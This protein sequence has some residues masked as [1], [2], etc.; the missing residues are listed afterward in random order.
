MEYSRSDLIIPIYIDTNTLL[1]LLASIEGGFSFVEK[2]TSR[3]MENTVSD[4]SAKVEVGTEFGIPNVL[5]LLK[6][7]IDGSAGRKK[8]EESSN[9]R[10]VER[11]HTYGS[12]LYR[13]RGGLHDDQMIKRFDGTDES[14]DTIETSDFVELRG[15]FRPNPF[16]DSLRSIERMVRLSQLFS[17]LGK[18]SSGG[19]KIGGNQ[20]V[21]VPASTATDQMKMMGK[22]LEGILEDID[23]QDIRLFVV[24]LDGNSNYKAIILMFME[25]LRDRS[26]KELAHKEYTLLGKV[27]R[28][29]T[30]ETD[31]R[32]DLLQGTALGGIGEDNLNQLS[33]LLNNM[34]NLNLP[35]AEA[36][37]KAPALEIVPIAIYV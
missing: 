23:K 16:A 29:I 13:L 21:R 9:Q 1:D 4:R 35:R 28:K 22:F 36:T 2:V 31:G 15:V 34:P 32:I 5:N 7:K 11:Y 17:D 30:N 20:R 25:Y 33:S 14:W 6:M 18:V 26:M 27:V 12:L 19:G 24:D 37:V 3:R 10:E 8:T